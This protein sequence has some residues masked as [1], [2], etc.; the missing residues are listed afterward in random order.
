MRRTL[1]ALIAATLLW[2][3]P[4]A[5]WLTNR[6]E[7]WFWPTWATAHPSFTY[8]VM[9]RDARLL[10]IHSPEAVDDVRR[11]FVR[12]TYGPGFMLQTHALRSGRTEWTFALELWALQLVLAILPAA[13]LREFIR[14]RR[15]QQRIEINPEPAVS[16][17]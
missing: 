13:A 17:S 5:L 16:A 6:G 9:T 7:T 4:P 12:K 15:K 3:V 10:L 1:I 14:A 2:L 11:Y 8:L